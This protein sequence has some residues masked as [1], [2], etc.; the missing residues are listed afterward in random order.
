MYSQFF[1]GFPPGRAVF[2]GVK[3][4]G[5]ITQTSADCLRITNTE[6]RGDINLADTPGNTIPNHGILKS[7]CAVQHKRN[8]K[9]I[10]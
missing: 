7:G 3:T 5:I 9:N 8:R 2:F 10:P 6:F 1:Y 4:T